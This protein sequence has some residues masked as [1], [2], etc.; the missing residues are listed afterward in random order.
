MYKCK[1]YIHYSYRLICFFSEGDSLE[2]LNAMTGRQEGENFSRLCKRNLLSRFSELLDHL[3]TTTEV[4]AG[5]VKCL[6]YGEIK[7]L[8]AAYQVSEVQYVCYLHIF[9]LFL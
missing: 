4:D 6:S 8:A 7:V 2:V 3:P 9:F 1:L 5:A